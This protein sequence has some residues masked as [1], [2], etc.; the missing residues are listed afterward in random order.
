[1]MGLGLYLS[2]EREIPNVDPL[3]ID[4]KSLARAQF[5][6]DDIARREQVLPIRSMLCADQKEALDFLEDIGLDPDEIKLP[7]EQWFPAGEGRRTVH[8]LLTHL[9]T[10]PDCVPNTER[11][12]ADLEAMD[13]VL[14]AAEAQQVRFHFAL[15]LPL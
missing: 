4:G 10:T 12:I 3:A 15:D 7:E 8:T 1:M 14:A 13:H 2:L 6:L 9:R 11:V 5:L